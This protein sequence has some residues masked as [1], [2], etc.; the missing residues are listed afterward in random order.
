[1]S[2]LQPAL[3]RTLLELDKLPHGSVV[4]DRFGHAW[5][6]SRNYW[7]RAYGDDASVSSWELCQRAP[8]TLATPADKALAR[9]KVAPVDPPAP[10]HDTPDM[11]ALL[12]G[13][14]E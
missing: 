13:D 1:M 8:I 9:V 2:G 11:L 6:E 5:Q 10:S 7:Y 12:E 14:P 3:R 4:I